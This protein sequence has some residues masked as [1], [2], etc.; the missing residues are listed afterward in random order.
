[1][2]KMLSV[3]LALSFSFTIAEVNTVKSVKEVQSI[4]KTEVQKPKPYDGNDPLIKT[5]HE[6][7]S[8][9]KNILVKEAN[10]VKKLKDPNREMHQ[11]EK[12]YL[13]KKS[14][15]LL[16]KKEM[17]NKD[18]L[19]DNQGFDNREDIERKALM[20]QKLENEETGLNSLKSLDYIQGPKKVVGSSHSSSLTR[21]HETLFISE[22]SEGSANHKYIEIYNPTDQ[23]IDLS[24]YAYPNSNNGASVDGDYDYWNAFD[25]GATIAPG[26]VYVVADAR[27]DASILEQ[28]DETHNYLSNG[29]DGVCLVSGGTW[30]DV[31]GDGDIDAGEMTGYEILD[32]VG[33]FSETDPGSGW[34]VAGVNNA[35]KDHT[36]VRKPS[37]V[38]GNEGNWATS[39]GTSAEDS[40]WVV[41]DQNT[42]TYVGAHEIEMEEDGPYLTEDFEGDFFSAGWS[43]DATGGWAI[44]EGTDYGPGF[45]ASG[46]Y[47]VFFNDYDYSSG[48]SGALYSPVVDLLGAVAPKLKFQYWD[49]SGGDVV[50]VQVSNPDG[51]YT[52]VFVTPTNT[53][54]WEELEVDLSAY[55]DLSVVVRFVGTSVWGTS[56]PHIDDVTVAEPPTFPI[57]VLSTGGVDLG[58][59]F[60]GGSKSID[61]AITNTGGADLTVVSASTNTK[62]T[63]SAL[64]GRIP[65]GT[66]ATAT[67]T[68]TPT[69]VADDEGSI[70][71]THNG[72]SSP[73]SIMVFGSGSLN[74][75][76]EGFDGPWVGTPSAPEGWSQISVSGTTPWSYYSYYGAA[77]GAWAS[78]GGEHVLISPQVDLTPGYNLKFYLDGSPSAGTDL[79]VQIGADNTDGTTGWTDLA[80]YVAGSNMPASWEEQV[81]SL[82]DYTGVHYIAFRLLDANG[83]SLFMDD[84][85]IEPL[86]T[87]PEIVLSQTDVDFGE[88]FLTLSSSKTVSVANDGGADATGTIAST[89]DKF[90]VGSTILSVVFGSSQE[91][92]VTYT[93]TEL[94]DVA[95][96]GYIILTHDG[97]SSPDSVMVVGLGTEAILAENFEGPWV[98]TPSAPEGWSQISVSGTTPWSYYSYYGAAY[99]AWASAG[100]EH[101]LITPA[102]DVTAG[103]NLSFMLDGSAS[104]GTDLKVQIGASNTDGTTGWTD[105]AHYVAGTD[106]PTTWEEKV[107][108][109]ASYT[110]VQYI[111]FRLLDADGYSLFL[112]DVRVDPV[113]TAPVL[114]VGANELS[115]TATALNQTTS[116]AV[117]ITN[118]GTGDLSGTVT[119]SVGFSGPATFSASDASIDV[120][121]SPTTSGMFSGTVSITSTG[122][123]DVIAVI[124]NAG[125]SIA[126]WDTDLDGDGYADWPAGWQ[127]AQET[128]GVGP[129]WEFFGGGG[130]TGDGYTS[131][132]AGGSGTVN[133]DWLMSPKYS[134]VDGSS[135]TFYASDDGGGGSY[136]DI[137]TVHIS[138]T[139]G[140]NFADFDV[141]LDTVINM[142][143]SWM[144]FDYDL[145]AYAGTEV[146]MAIVY[147]GEWGYGLN[148]DDVAAPEIVIEA[149]PVI[150]EYPMALDFSSGD[151]VTAVATTDTTLFEYF[152]I[153]GSDLEVTAIALEG[154]F[155]LN[156][157]VTFP[158]TTTPGSISGFEVIFSPLAD[159]LYM[160][161]MTIA[162]NAGDDLVIP[163]Y[164][165]GFDGV[166]RETFGYVADDGYLTP[167][168]EGWTFSDDGVMGPT[169]QPFSNATGASWSRASLSGNGLMYHT[170]N[171]EADA[172]TAISGPIVLAALA[173]GFHYELDTEEYIAYGGDANDICGIAVSTD[174]GVT[175]TLVGEA[176]Y[177]ATTS[178][179]SNNYDLTGYAG[180]TVHFA[181]I[182]RGTYANAWGVS[183]MVVRKKEDP[184][185][186]IFAHSALVFPVT[187]LTQSIDRKVY[188]QNIG[189]GTF[190]GDITYPA[191]M[192]GPA[193]IAGLVPGTVDSMV[194]TY[195]P[196]APGIEAGDIT[197]DG[198]AS[199]GGM[200]SLG[201]EAN[202]GELAF[203][204]ETQ[205]AGWQ[206]YSLGGQ[207]W[208]APSGAIYQDTWT[209]FGGTGHSG[210]NYY[211]VYSYDA[212]W[213]GVDDYL[214][215]PRYSLSDA[216]EVI[217]FY[218]SGGDNTERDSL[219]VWVSTERPQMG[220][221][222]DTDGMRVD[223]GFVNTSAFSMVYESLPSNVGWDSVNVVL[224]T[225]Q[226]DVWV[227]IHS[228]QHY[229]EDGT[230]DGWM[231]KIDDLGTPNIYQN[232]LPV[233]RVG[234]RYDFGIT[235]PNG[236]SVKYFI[237]NTGMVDLVIDTMNFENGEYFD[238]DYADT[239]PITI[240]PGGVDSIEV[241]WMPEMEGRQTDTL[242]YFSNYTVG[243]FDAFGFGTD[244][245]V[246]TADAFNA[247]P[248]AVMLLTPDPSSTPLVT[249]DAN[250]ATG[251]TDF[252]WTNTTDPDGT[253]IE[254]IFEIMVPGDTLDT[255]LS[256]NSFSLD[257]ADLIW[258]MD[259]LMVTS[260]E[261][262]WDVHAYDGFEAT[263]SS[264]GPWALTFDGGWVLGDLD[265]NTIPD[266]FALHNNYPNPFNP[267]T[268]I[269]YD[270][271]VA[272]DVRIDIYNIAG[273]KVRTL[274]SRE[275]QPGRYK[276]QW[277]ATNEFGSPVATGMYIYKIHAKD[278]T[279]V[280]KL[281]LM[282]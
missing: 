59:V 99:G 264:N 100:G 137:M 90:V 240:V 275:H 167:W 48:T 84:V 170:Y 249:I 129:G 214:V 26:D 122:G 52:S 3:C 230:K 272:S 120:A 211:G 191:S 268:N 101:V 41:Y 228:V 54:G 126:N 128:P 262:T 12:E 88:V 51:S 261:A 246:F 174:A 10:K 36:L 74:A 103:Y 135:F 80:H 277:N 44:D 265:N 266:V 104:T 281:L 131:A 146:R 46:T 267:V 208:V 172:D 193:S 180:Q 123:D 89:N 64:P 179:Y 142:G 203:D 274:V 190:T 5:K 14:M 201:V 157:S 197:I 175:F 2:Y 188:F 107:I 91:V 260:L 252:Y 225:D 204:M 169:D 29:D 92:V 63:I 171:S 114:V 158:I 78:A 194:V 17:I 233:L 32:C 4:S 113:P 139:G 57:A 66:T 232:P 117:S 168:S 77:Y 27:S 6:G 154:P 159:S 219:N 149:G 221:T 278:F 282:K 223:T 105:L 71:F 164:G 60:I 253:P 56:N 181:L 269:R 242:R 251:S 45:A 83:Y 217:S 237:R 189:V 254:Y 186:P 199:N 259:S 133:S 248:G 98:G 280:K 161:S 22:A 209:W 218:A 19:N 276:I 39:A 244:H 257:H 258:L 1:M 183:T 166:Y 34:P 250:N 31:N 271:P 18:P 198:S 156:S 47:C 205:S 73:D 279:S 145:S 43:T 102:L 235:S 95:D 224:P 213:G 185:I 70:I 143:Q 215:S 178:T 53:A 69:E 68:Y 40:E 229:K 173:D 9:S 147:R 243:E 30:S 136:P 50:D 227:M 58:D 273:E 97:A 239:Y 75:L 11:E 130:H 140:N 28:A 62:F 15:Q 160:G 125:V 37:V 220:F 118:T 152:N 165:S 192:T 82:A 106:M 35:T 112:D 116:Q 72:D 270:I 195:T 182:Y 263:E 127:T 184:V 241:F 256:E 207:P 132:G 81:I 119:Y 76:T 124:G 231:L 61:V 111:A 236:D 200:I 96:T 212:Y 79:K 94:S 121:F 109:L 141:P 151:E 234:T 55:N 21:E 86:P 23:T 24:G 138:T 110:G 255:L 202:A 8:S 87:T 177:A 148:V 42:W 238:V 20:Q 245:S 108:S 7:K 25:D 85:T 134:A 216:S 187:A 162:N 226:S 206:D 16:S 247:P 176:D 38:S 67:I 13:Y 155:S 210:P 93:P 49:S 222:V 144:P 196:S 153:G 163:L 150:Y 65:A 115:F 33:D